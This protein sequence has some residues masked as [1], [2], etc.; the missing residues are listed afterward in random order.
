MTKYYIANEDNPQII[1]RV[2]WGGV[3]VGMDDSPFAPSSVTLD[4]LETVSDMRRITKREAKSLFPNL[5]K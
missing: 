4:E 5:I 2:D 3:T 1:W